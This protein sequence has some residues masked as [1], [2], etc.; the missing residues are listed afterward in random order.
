MYNLQTHL[1]RALLEV[2]SSGVATT[3]EDLDNFVKCTLL[4]AQ[5]HL[6]NNQKDGTTDD[7]ME[8]EYI[9]GALEFLVEYEFV[10]LQND[11]ETNEQHY[12]ATRLGMACLGFNFSN[13]IALNIQI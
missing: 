5:K 2:I 3:K 4:S 12:V 10:R 1:K 6:A 8:D 7:E 13:I 11:E 9:G